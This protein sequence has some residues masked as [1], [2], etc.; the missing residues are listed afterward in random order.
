MLISL[1]LSKYCLA[2]VL[3]LLNSHMK[4]I[5]SFVTGILK[6]NV[7]VHYWGSELLGHTTNNDLLNKIEMEQLCLT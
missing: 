4:W 6:Q 5:L 7:S 3:S 1:I 2:K